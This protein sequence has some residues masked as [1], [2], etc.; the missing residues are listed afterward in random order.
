M[1]CHVKLE[2]NRYPE[3]W[4]EF[5]SRKDVANFPLRSL[6]RFFF[7]GD[8]DTCNFNT[9]HNY[10]STLI[11]CH[12]HGK[13]G[14]QEKKKGDTDVILIALSW[15]LPL[16]WDKVDSTVRETTCS[17]LRRPSIRRSSTD[18]FRVSDTA[19]QR[20]QTSKMHGAIFGLYHFGA[21]CEMP[22]S[23]PK[24]RVIGGEIKGMWWW[25]QRQLHGEFELGVS[26]MD[27]ISYYKG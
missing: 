25:Q 14:L 13:Y 3:E 10:W 16:S 19:T 15:H 5:S 27:P 20:I 9:L 4:E 6:F 21:S 2:H 17:S 7:P 22:K 12:S 8:G 26:S 23:A 11:S 1:S 18:S 24:R